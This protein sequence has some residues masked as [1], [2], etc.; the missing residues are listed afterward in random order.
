M[1]EQPPTPNTNQLRC[2][3]TA[4]ATMQWT[5]KTIQSKYNLQKNEKEIK[6]IQVQTYKLLEA[7]NIKLLHVNEK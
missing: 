5:T 6:T 2:L 1:F 7:R 3:H 4:T